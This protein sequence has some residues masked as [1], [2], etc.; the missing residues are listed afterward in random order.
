[1][2]KIIY[3]PKGAAAEYSEWAANLYNGCSARC[4][5]C[6]NRKGRFS[7]VLGGD[8]PTLK[9]QLINKTTAI[10]IFRKEM[11]MNIT[12]LRDKGLFFSFVSD[13]MLKDTIELSTYLM[14]QALI[15]DI[16]VKLLTKQTWWVDDFCKEIE[17]NGTVWNTQ[18]LHLLAVGFSLTGCDELEPGAGENWERTDAIKKIKR[19]GVK[20]FASIEPIITVEDSKRVVRRCDGCCDLYKVGLES[21]K[22]YDK[23]ELLEFFNWISNHVAASKIYFKDSFLKAIGVEREDLTGKIYVGRDL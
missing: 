16:P 7:K 18:K 15:N 6:Y 1:M 23:T 17:K 12:E 14:R 10:E 4:S 2:G 19:L 11:K 9:K 3:Q 22:K 21:G 8:V 20:T 13:P 5:Y